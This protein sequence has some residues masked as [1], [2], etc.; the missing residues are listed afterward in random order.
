MPNSGHLPFPS[1]SRGFVQE[2]GTMPV[3]QPLDPRRE[4]L[5]AF[6]HSCRVSEYVVD[7]LPSRL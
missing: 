3:V 4:L 5:E 6:E 2:R 1:L 7:V